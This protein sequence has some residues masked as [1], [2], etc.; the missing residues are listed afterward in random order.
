MFDITGASDARNTFVMYGGKIHGGYSTCNP[1]TP[2]NRLGGNVYMRSYTNLY[3]LGGEIADGIV[4]A[5]ANKVGA[6]G[7]LAIG[8]NAIAYISGGKISNGS[9]IEG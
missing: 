9:V 7:N 3:M 6:G 2:E 5:P 1:A 8:S 4:E